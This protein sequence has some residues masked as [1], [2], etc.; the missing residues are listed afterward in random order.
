MYLYHYAS[1]KS[2]KE[3]DKTGYIREDTYVTR[4]EKGAF[5][6][7]VSAG[8]GKGTIYSLGIDD[9]DYEWGHTIGP[10]MYLHNYK[11][12]QKDLRS[13]AVMDWLAVA[14]YLEVSV[15]DELLRI[16]RKCYDIE[17]LYI[18][19]ELLKKCLM[20]LKLDIPTKESIANRLLKSI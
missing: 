6:F 11:Y 17:K 13:F 9:L 20:V 12:R 4:T 2:E 8:K 16:N 15:K 19:K 1:L 18:D 14:D 10:D 5:A 3:I 7:L